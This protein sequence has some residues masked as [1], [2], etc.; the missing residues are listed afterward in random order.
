M[1][2]QIFGLWLTLLSIAACAAPAQLD[3]PQAQLQIAG[4]R[5]V[6][7]LADTPELRERGLMFQQSAD[8]GMLLLYPAP[9]MISL[10]MRNTD[11]SLDVAFIDEQWQIMSIKPLQPLDETPV[12][13]PAAA[14]AA[15]EMPRGWFA[16][17]QIK[18][19]DKLQ[20]LK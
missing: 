12:S 4:S 8:P 18:A 10:W 1:T 15:L 19:G 6:V 5:I 9:R 13:A 3:F 7:Q 2:K 16:E 14:I 11:L 17:R 20:L